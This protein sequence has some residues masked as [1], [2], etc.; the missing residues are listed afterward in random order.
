MAALITRAA[1]PDSAFCE[2]SGKK[3]GAFAFFPF[4]NDRICLFQGNPG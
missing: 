4:R 2:G 1:Q 3:T